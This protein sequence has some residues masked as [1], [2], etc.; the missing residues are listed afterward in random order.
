[1]VSDKPG[2]IGWGG[3]CDQR[4]MPWCFINGTTHHLADDEMQKLSDGVS[5]IIESKRSKTPEATH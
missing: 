1:M 2:G 3:G 5:E 4:M